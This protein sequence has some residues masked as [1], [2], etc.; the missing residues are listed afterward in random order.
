VVH[1]VHPDVVDQAMA[2]VVGP[3]PGKRGIIA[4]GLGRSYGDAAQNAGGT[5]LDL[6]GMDRIL[7]IDDDALL[8]R[9]QPGV[10]Y[11]RLLPELASRGLMFPVVPGTRHVTIGGAIAS[12]IHGKSHHRDGTIAAH[13]AAL[14]ICTPSG[15]CREITPHGDPELFAATLGG[16]GLLGVI[17]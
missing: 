10:T 3:G 8:V 1:A 15:G 5:V 9:V 13:L 2:D 7:S 11:G 6:T 12:D 16:M 4:R 14:V 17:V